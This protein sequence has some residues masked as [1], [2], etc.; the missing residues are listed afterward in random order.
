[1]TPRAPWVSGA[2]GDQAGLVVG[3]EADARVP[4][5]AAALAGAEGI[6]TGDPQASAGEQHVIRAEAAG[7]GRV[8]HDGAAGRREPGHAG[9]ADRA[10][11]WGVT[12][13]GV[14]EPPLVAAEIGRVG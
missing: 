5:D 2:R 10:G 4:A 3:H 9:R 8:P 14:V 1:M 11:S 6:V 7:P 12:V 13:Q